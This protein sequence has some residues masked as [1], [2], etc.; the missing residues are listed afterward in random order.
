LL[1]KS[2]AAKQAAGRR[3]DALCREIES[4]N[5]RYYVL[6]EPSISDGEFDALLSELQ[7]LEAEY[8]EL[9]TADSPTQR[10]GGAPQQGFVTVQHTVPMLSTAACGAPWTERPLPMWSS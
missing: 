7:A 10:V 1:N 2:D 6:A 8:P 5:H 3:H 9:I 4:H